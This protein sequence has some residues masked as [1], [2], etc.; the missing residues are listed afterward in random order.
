MVEEHSRG[1]IR[2][3]PNTSNSRNINRLFSSKKTSK[4]GS[5]Q[6]TNEIVND[7]AYKT[8]Y[9]G[10]N[11]YRELLTPIIK[12]GDKTQFSGFRLQQ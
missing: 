9:D 1:G 2:G 11:F 8:S 7:I 4:N 10:E 3:S 5:F 6:M 12:P